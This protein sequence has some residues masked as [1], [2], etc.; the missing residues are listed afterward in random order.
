MREKGTYF[1]KKKTLIEFGCRYCAPLL[2]TEKLIYIINFYLT[3]GWLALHQQ[4][5][6]NN[7]HFFTW[8]R[9][10][11]IQYFGLCCATSLCLLSQLLAVP[12]A[13]SIGLK[14]GE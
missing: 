14:S 5:F 6:V 8:L 13:S 4:Y 7:L 9:A 12:K 11:A 10:R 2:I 1:G 3:E